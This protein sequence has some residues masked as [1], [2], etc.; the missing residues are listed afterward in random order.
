MF[1]SYFFKHMCRVSHVCKCVFA[2]PDLTPW[3]SESLCSLWRFMLQCVNQWILFFQIILPVI[4]CFIN[5]HKWLILFAVVCVLKRIQL[6]EL[7][8][9]FSHGRHSLLCDSLW[10]SVNFSV[11]TFFL[12]KCFCLYFQLT[13]FVPVY[14]CRIW[15]DSLLKWMNQFRFTPMLTQ[16][17]FCYK[18]PEKVVFCHLNVCFFQASM[19]CVSH[20]CTFVS[21]EPHPTPWISESFHS[22]LRFAPHSFSRSFEFF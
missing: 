17:I 8:N 14:V 7:V 5:G 10:E 3:I 1:L 6:F 9:H 11:I 19:N 21:A 16:W 4:V 13:V 2:K 20:I 12:F 15:S 18:P 22:F